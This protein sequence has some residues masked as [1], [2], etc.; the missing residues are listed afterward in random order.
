MEQHVYTVDVKW[1][2][3]LGR[4]HRI[5]KVIKALGIF[6]PWENRP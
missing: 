6:V 1:T 5:A 4:G 3:N 2:G